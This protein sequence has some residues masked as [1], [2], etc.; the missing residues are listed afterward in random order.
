MDGRPPTAHLMCIWLQSRGRMMKMPPPPLHY[1]WRERERMISM[2]VFLP[3]WYDMFEKTQ[4][5]K[6]KKVIVIEVSASH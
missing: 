6:K 3:P 2:N 5:K 4:K 1:R